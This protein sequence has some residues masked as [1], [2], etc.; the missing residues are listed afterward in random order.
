[1]DRPAAIPPPARPADAGAP[2]VRRAARRPGRSRTRRLA[3]RIAIAAIATLLSLLVGQRFEAAVADIVLDLAAPPPRQDVVV[4]LVDEATVERLPARS[5]IDRGFLA[6]LLREI[7]AAG[8]AAI[9]LDFIFSRPTTPEKDEALAAAIREAEAPVVV[10]FAD[11]SDGL[12][13]RQAE[14]VRLLPGRSGRATLLRDESDGRVRLLPEAGAVPPFALA[15]AEAARRADVMPQ[16]RIVYADG[17]FATYAA[18]LVPVLPDAWLTDRFVLVGT[19]LEGVD[20]HATPRTAILGATGGEVPGVVIHAH[21]LSQILSGEVR[22]PAPP[23]LLAAAALAAALAGIS[24]RTLGPVAALLLAGAA[25]VVFL[26]VAV[27]IVLETVLTPPIATPLVAFGSAGVLT[28][29]E[30]WRGDRRERARIVGMFG[31]Y[32]SPRVVKRLV[33]AGAEP[34]LGGERREVTHLFTD[35]EGFTGLSET[36]EPAV[37]GEILNSYLNGIVNCV[38]EADGTVDKLVGDAVVAFFGAPDAQ[39]DHAARAVAAARA[40]AAFAEGERWRW[41]ARG[42]RLGRTRVGVH[43]GEAVVGNFG[44]DRFFDYTAVGDTVNVAA[45]LEAANRRTGTAV[46]VSGAT[47]ARAPGEFRPV[48]RMR[49]KGRAASVP[50]FEPVASPDLAY[51]AA[52]EAMAAGDPGALAKFEALAEARPSDPL[53]RLHLARLREGASDDLIDAP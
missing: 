31:R 45:R 35:L 26:G 3:P 8:P 44:G 42:V 43:T 47:R 22:R 37:V 18:S 5:P 41:E 11:E 33:E 4:V 29:A 28:L 51:E 6:E 30:R 24:L 13:A 19:G 20:R 1:M 23:V 16:G 48:G 2:D 49:V 25:I 53:A 27:L 9:G 17:E 7:D 32:V 46:L 15:L 39:P 34:R 10:A 14:H 40:I 36:L 52:Y 50:A 12:T 38:L 21:I